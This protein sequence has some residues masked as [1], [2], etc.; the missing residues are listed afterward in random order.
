[1]YVCHLYF[2]QP[3]KISFSIALV[4]RWVNFITGSS[5]AETLDNSVITWYL[6]LPAGIPYLLMR[7]D[8]VLHIKKFV[9]KN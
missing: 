1:M 4:R 7:E 3:F 2:H 6:L 5:G 9:S 8:F